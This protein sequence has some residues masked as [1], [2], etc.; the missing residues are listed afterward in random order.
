MKKIKV[1]VLGDDGVTPTKKEMT[2]EP[3]GDIAYVYISTENYYGYYFLIVEVSEGVYMIL[4]VMEKHT[5]DYIKLGFY[6]GNNIVEL[7][8]KDFIEAISYNP[9]RS[10]IH[11]EIAKELGLDTTPLIQE[12]E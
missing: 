3:F 5:L 8:R 2:V 10:Q 6:M 4:K 9:N 7:I 1:F 12:V 11:I